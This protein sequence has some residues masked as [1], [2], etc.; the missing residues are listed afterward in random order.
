[1]KIRY[2]ENSAVDL[3]LWDALVRDSF[4][5]S[6]F[7]SS[8]FLDI[9]C[10]GWA[11]LVADNYKAVLPLPLKN[12]LGTNYVLMPWFMKWL[13]PVGN[14]LVRNDMG[15]FLS[16]IPFPVV[17][18]DLPACVSLDG[19]LGVRASTKQGFK[20]DLIRSYS[21]NRAAYRGLFRASL[22]RAIAG[23]L[24]VQSGI[25]PLAF[26]EFML[27]DAVL[28]EKMNQDLIAILRN[29]AVNCVRYKVGI[30]YG[31]YD[32]ANALCA[33]VL[34]AGSHNQFFVICGAAN[35]KGLETG[36]MYLLFDYFLEYH[37]ELN[38]TLD[39]FGLDLPNLANFAGDLGAAAQP[40]LSFK[41]AKLPWL[42]KLFNV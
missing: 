25:S 41:S 37:S 42:L 21:R 18:M 31:V 7:M 20:L 11:A 27:R 6:V 17:R 23:G 40:Y 3:E 30:V 1:M 36:A 15:L 5:G 26:V 33:A 16:E 38:I 8:W 13:K 29:L 22:V 10:D 12:I 35:A 14:D 19:G 32:R 24:S 2:I 9:V 39:L 34:F 4:N 28:G